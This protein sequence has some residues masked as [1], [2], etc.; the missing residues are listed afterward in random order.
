[1]GE[2]T[3]LDLISHWQSIAY[4]GDTPPSEYEARLHKLYS[5]LSGY[6]QGPPLGLDRTLLSAEVPVPG[7]VI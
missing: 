1:M 7:D 3:L 6:S 5:S 2:F 4:I